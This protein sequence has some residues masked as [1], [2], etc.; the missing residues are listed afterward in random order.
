MQKNRN[1]ET[2]DKVKKGPEE[3]ILRAEGSRIK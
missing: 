2:I 1:F 3:P